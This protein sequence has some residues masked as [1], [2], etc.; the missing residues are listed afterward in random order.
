MFL[1]AALQS[2]D[3]FLYFFRV[4]VVGLEEVA[5]RF[6][7]GSGPGRDGGGVAGVQSQGGV[8]GVE[9][10]LWREGWLAVLFL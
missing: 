9:P 10:V 3:S 8:E 1:D 6:P 4:A 5:A 7:R 2:D